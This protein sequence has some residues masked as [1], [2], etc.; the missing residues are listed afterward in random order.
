MEAL[1]PSGRTIYFFGALGGLLFGY[2]TGV[3]SGAL[4][5]IPDDFKLTPFLQGAIVAALL[6]GAM[7]GA[8]VAG[9]LSDR[10][11]RKQLIVA[12]AVVFTIGSLLAALAPSVAVLIAARFI[13]GLAVG[14]AALVVPLYL[15]EIAPTEV[16]GAIAS[17]N[18]LMIVA[19]ILAAFVVNAILASSGDWRLMLGLAA[20]PSLILLV[21]MLFM[22]EKPRYLV[23]A[24]EEDSAREVIEDLP[25]DERPEA[26]IEE[27][28]EVE[29]HEEGDVG[30][31]GLWQA[32]WV[33]PA[34]LAATGLAVFQQFVGINTII[35]YAPTTLTDVG[36]GKTSAIYAN[37]IIGV[38]NVLMTVIAIRIIDRVGRKPMLYAGVAG[39]VGSLLVL[40]ISLSVLATPHHPG[41]PAAVITLICLG[42]F[43]ASFAATW[44]P[45]VW[46]MIPEVLP[47]SLRGTAMGVAVF[48]NWGANF[49]VSQ[50]F[51]PLLSSLGPGPVFLG[52]AA[53]GLLAAVFVKAFVTETKG[54]SLEEIETDL[55]DAA[56][57]TGRRHARPRQAAISR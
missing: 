1:R 20:V 7:I 4:L 6:L 54:R 31:R 21:G 27:I 45:V 49:L 29:E 14:S 22:P 26:R 53:L 32:K 10:L 15:A 52:Y 30:L 33:R 50:T 47:L 34:L 13:I 38:V 46:V 3:I 9:R 57:G 11:G 16:R 48:C 56:G 41:D 37:L 35:Y 8:A 25:G 24:G 5:F 51:P 42:T 39:M 28:R 17:L 12:A 19:G 40:G 18:Q 55:Q 44:G 2:D 36:F 23:H 43:I